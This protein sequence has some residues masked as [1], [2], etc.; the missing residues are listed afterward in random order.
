MSQARVIKEL[1]LHTNGLHMKRMANF[2]SEAHA[3]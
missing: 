3:I 1:I 2:Q